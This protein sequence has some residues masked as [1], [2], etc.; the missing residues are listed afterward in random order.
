MEDFVLSN[1]DKVD[2]RRG[3]FTRLGDIRAKAAEE[4]VRAAVRRKIKSDILSG[5]MNALPDIVQMAVLDLG[6]EYF[7]S[8]SRGR[9]KHQVA[10]RVFVTLEGRNDKAIDPM[11]FVCAMQRMVK[12]RA[13]QGKG[14]FKLEQRAESGDPHGWH[15]HWDLQID[16]PVAFSTFCQQIYQSKMKEFLRPVH[17]VDGKVT[18]PGVDI[19]VYEDRHD[20]YM[21]GEKTDDKKAK[22]RYDVELRD[23]MKMPHMFVY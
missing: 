9:P 12:K 7:I 3:Q 13:L 22:V 5:N 15:I 23:K 10:G 8:E 11:L 20:K 1:P 18:Y 21:L 6:A 2:Y 16:V 19:K 14:R 17:S 4:I